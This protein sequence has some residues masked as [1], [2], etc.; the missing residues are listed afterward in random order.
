MNVTTKGRQPTTMARDLQSWTRFWKDLKCNSTRHTRPKS[1]QAPGA[2]FDGSGELS[3]GMTA[4]GKA[5]AKKRVLFRI[6]SDWKVQ[7]P[8]IAR[9]K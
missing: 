4:H 3:K 6:S 5:T 7:D 9:Q 8:S 2:S 1:R